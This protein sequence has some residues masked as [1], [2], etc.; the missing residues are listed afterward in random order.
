MTQHEATILELRSKSCQ[1]WQGLT[2]LV[3][4]MW[5]SKELQFFRD[6]VEQFVCDRGAGLLCRAT[7]DVR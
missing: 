4:S 1:V 2:L 3:K 5:E 7:G 6:V